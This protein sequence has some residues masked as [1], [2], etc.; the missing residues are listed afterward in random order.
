MVKSKRFK[1]SFF[2]GYDVVNADTISSYAYCL[3]VLA[4]LQSVGVIQN[5]QNPELGFP[6][7]V[8]SVPEIKT[9]TKNNNDNLYRQ[10]DVSFQKSIHHEQFQNACHGTN[11]Q[12]WNPKIGVAA[13]FYG[14]MKFYGSCFK[15]S[16]SYRISIRDGG[17]IQS[18]SVDQKR[19]L[20]VLDPFEL[21]RNCTAMVAKNLDLI[22][23]EF[24]LAA[25]LIQNGNI[26][27]VFEKIDRSGGKKR[28]FQKKH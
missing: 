15:Y 19:C 27:K 4:Y 22:I 10:V 26:T 21:E 23:Q 13:L 1:Q 16:S 18:S 24:R 9:R 14:F 17:F 25:T 20:F 11:Q 28:I 8:V 5:I 6:K 2:R 3:M 7:E 12:V